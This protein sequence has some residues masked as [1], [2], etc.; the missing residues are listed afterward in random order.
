MHSTLLFSF[1]FRCFFFVLG[2]H[3]FV[4]FLLLMIGGQPLKLNLFQ[5]RPI[6]FDHISCQLHPGFKNISYSTES[7]DNKWNWHPWQQQEKESNFILIRLFM[8]PWIQTKS[9]WFYQIK[10]LALCCV[11]LLCE[12]RM[13]EMVA[14]ISW[15]VTSRNLKGDFFFLF[16]FIFHFLFRV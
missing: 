16:K 2:K 11:H 4:T 7:I 8:N 3:T 14:A 5:M 9:I 1:K 12:W 10:D 13:A 15:I 6:V